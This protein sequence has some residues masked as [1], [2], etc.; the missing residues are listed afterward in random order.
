MLKNRYGN[1]ESMNLNFVIKFRD[2]SE[3]RLSTVD[4]VIVRSAI[5]LNLKERKRLNA[6]SKKDWNIGRMLKRK[7]K[8]RM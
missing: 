5:K 2:S 8:E 6:I 7:R 4:K 1:N 3:Q